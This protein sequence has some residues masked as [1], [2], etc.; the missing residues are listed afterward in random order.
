MPENL[1]RRHLLRLASSSLALPLLMSPLGPAPALGAAPTPEAPALPISDLFPSHPPELVREVVLVAHFDLNRLKEL[2]DARP[3]LAK[4]AWDWGFG[5]WEDALGAASHMGNRAIAEYLI[6]KGARPSLFSAA[7]LGQLD[8]VKA[9]IAARLGSQAI[10]G[11]HSISLLAH[12]RVGGEIARPVYDFLQPLGGADSDPAVPLDE[13]DSAKLTGTYIFGLGITQQAVVDADMKMYTGS[14]MY[15]HAPQLN[16]T[17]KA[18]MPRPLFHLGNLEFFP[19]G[20]PQARIR[21]AEDARGVA[22]SVID[23]D[24][25][26]TARRSADTK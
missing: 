13:T 4:A 23:G 11:P 22:M 16:W 1:S 14:K 19:A 8:T 10:R 5:D 24:L 20:A 12:A 15:S 21:F 6:A 26:L 9:F 7:M 18:A 2:V 25:I 17:R 3:A